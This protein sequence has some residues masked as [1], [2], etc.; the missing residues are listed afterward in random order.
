ML[1]NCIFFLIETTTD[2]MTHLRGFKRRRN[3]RERGVLFF[4]LAGLC[5]HTHTHTS[6]FDHRRNANI[7]VRKYNTHAFFRDKHTVPL[8]CT[9]MYNSVR[10]D[11]SKWRPMTIVPRTILLAYSYSVVHEPSNR[12]VFR[13]IANKLCI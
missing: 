9:I 11:Y 12:V 5:T 3:C 13:N 8:L 4:T 1:E 6:I 2:L 10:G 7:F